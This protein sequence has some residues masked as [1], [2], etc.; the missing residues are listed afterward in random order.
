[1][2]ASLSVL[3]LTG[4]IPWLIQSIYTLIY[5]ACRIDPH[6]VLTGDSGSSIAIVQKFVVRLPIRC[7]SDLRVDAWR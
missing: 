1:M 5:L 3:L 2:L 6:N 4:A 7:W